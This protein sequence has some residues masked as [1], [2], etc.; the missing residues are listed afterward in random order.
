MK[1]RL[2]NRGVASA[3]IFVAD[4]WADGSAIQPIERPYTSD[5]LVL[6]YS[7]NLGLAHDVETLKGAILALSNDDRFRFLFIGSGGRHQELLSFGE[8]YRLHSIEVR[9]YVERS[10]LGESLAEGDI[11]LVTQR[12]ACCGS[13]VPSKVYGLLAAGRPILFVGPRQATPALIVERFHCGW[14]VDCGAV[15]A[16][17]QLLIH[18]A[19]HP[20]EVRLAGCNAR[21]ALLRH[22]DLP[23][24][25]E[26]IA[27]ILGASSSGYDASGLHS[28]HS[29]RSS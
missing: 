25:V 19:A 27:N 6:L 16:L 18:L 10:S 28:L 2:V 13:V 7:G 4:N 29:L 22:Y 17:T 15:S 26:R 23:L 8:L 11:G 5:H 20:E 9:P 21:D 1:Q 14:Q 3:S 24:G 12:D